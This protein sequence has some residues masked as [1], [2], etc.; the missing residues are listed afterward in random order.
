M[1]RCQPDWTKAQYL[2]IET[3]L[4]LYQSWPET[5]ARLAHVMYYYHED[6]AFALHDALLEIG[7]PA[8]AEHFAGDCT[9]PGHRPGPNQCW[10]LRLFCGRIKHQ[11][12]LLPT[13]TASD[14]LGISAARFR[15]LAKRVGLAEKGYYLESYLWEPQAVLKLAALLP[16]STAG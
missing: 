1:N 11:Q 14:W 15:R 13:S 3:H 6:C 5:V 4:D 2:E 9:H 7:C 8:I 16:A 12:Q 10:F